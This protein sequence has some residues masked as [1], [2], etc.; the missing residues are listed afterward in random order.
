MTPSTRHWLCSIGAACT[1]GLAS[2]VQA[3]QDPW[4][5]F[6][7]LL[8]PLYEQVVS[9][10]QQQVPQVLTSLQE[11]WEQALQSALGPLGMPDPI[12]FRTEGTTAS[13]AAQDS[14]SPNYFDTPTTRG[15][16]AAEEADRQLTRGR[17]A[18]NLGQDGQS[19]T[20]QDVDRTQSY[21]EKTFTSAT[22]MGAV[23]TQQWVSQAETASSEAQVADVTQDV[24][25]AMSRQ[26]LNDTRLLAGLGD[27]LKQSGLQLYYQT[28]ILGATR[29]DALKAREDTQL[30]NL[31]L[32]NIS[33]QL[34]QQN[35]LTRAE[36][37]GQTA[38]NTFTSALMD[39]SPISPAP[40]NP[41][42]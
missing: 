30:A 9:Y 33:S 32:T 19:L 38:R 28:E 31:N 3:A 34:A 40:G 36:L 1:I 4:E 8:T 6:Y 18:S 14:V 22:A 20:Q 39:L 12:K 15:H 26:Q 25:K 42:P 11:Q 27:M 17:I 16:L 21:I 2:P 5:F 41:S 13:Y 23:N 7:S 35:Q 37:V 24:L 29:V 10:V